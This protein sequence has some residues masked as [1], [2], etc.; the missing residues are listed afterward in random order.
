MEKEVKEHLGFLKKLGVCV[1]LLIIIWGGFWFGLRRINQMIES[2]RSDDFRWVVQVDKT[3]KNNG[4]FVLSGFAFE[5]DKTA[6]KKAYT[7]VLHNMKTGEYSYPKMK[8]TK[9][10]DVNK[11]FRCEYDYTESGFI[12]TIDESKFD[13]NGDYEVLLRP[14]NNK[15]PYKFGTYLAKGK[16][17]YTNPKSYAQPDVSGS[18]LEDVVSKG[19]LRVYEPQKHMYVYQY[20]GELYWFIDK[21]YSFVDD[22]VKVQ[23]QLNTTQPDRLPEVRLKNEW[24]W[25]NIS[26]MLSWNELMDIPEGCSYRVAKKAIPTEYSV[27]K[28]WTGFEIDGE[29]W[30]TYFRPRYVFE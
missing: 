3:E 24:D 11:Y 12:A 10:E 8:Y 5:L 30:L 14:V 25:D 13:V 6:E 17:V 18:G 2:V 23:Y 20:D 15:D 7:I 4:K 29:L 1:G 9:R 19:V 16:L 22:N 28:I 27:S 26:F 21:E